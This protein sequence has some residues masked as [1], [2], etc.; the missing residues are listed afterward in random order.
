MSENSRGEKCFHKSSSAN[1]IGTGQN[2]TKGLQSSLGK[3]KILYLEY[4]LQFN[5][6]FVQDYFTCYDL[7][8]IFFVTLTGH[9]SLNYL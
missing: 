5:L 2:P 1:P 7:S 3:L 8:Q 4:L 6:K 9:I